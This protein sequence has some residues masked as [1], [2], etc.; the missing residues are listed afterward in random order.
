[1]EGSKSLNALV[2]SAREGRIC[3]GRVE[4]GSGRENVGEREDE[5][6][7][8]EFGVAIWALVRYA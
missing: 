1:M 4:A 6:G 7:L 2:D 5:A 3:W 8:L